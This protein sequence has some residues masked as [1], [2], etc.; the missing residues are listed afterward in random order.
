MASCVCALRWI[1]AVAVGNFGAA[2]RSTHIVGRDLVVLENPLGKSVKGRI[3]ATETIRPGVL[4]MGMGTGGR[5]SPGLGK[6]TAFKETTPN[7]NLLVD[8]KAHSPIMGMPC[9]ADM[10]V[11]IRKA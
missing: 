11:K 2:T 9:Y 5:F 7:A 4:R 8:P 3:N 6:T 1:P 10:V